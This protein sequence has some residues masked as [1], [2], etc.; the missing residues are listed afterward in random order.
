[1]CKYSNPLPIDAIT[2][3]PVNVRNKESTGHEK[4]VHWSLGHQDQLVGYNVRGL[5]AVIRQEKALRLYDCHLIVNKEAVIDPN[6]FC[7]DNVVL[8][9]PFDGVKYLIDPNLTPVQER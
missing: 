5:R 3:S 4:T 8:K 6:A 2:D 1:M 9:V 7:N